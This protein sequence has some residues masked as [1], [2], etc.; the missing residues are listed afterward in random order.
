MKL[1]ANERIWLGMQLDFYR[2]D[3]WNRILD[4]G[5]APTGCDPNARVTGRVSS[6]GNLKDTVWVYVSGEGFYLIQMA[7]VKDSR[8][9]IVSEMFDWTGGV[10]PQLIKGERSGRYHISDLKYSNE[11]YSVYRHGRGGYFVVHNGTGLMLPHVGAYRPHN[12]SFDHTHY[13]KDAKAYADMVLDIDGMRTLDQPP[14]SA[15]KMLRDRL[16]QLRTAREEEAYR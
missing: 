1:T 2:D 13:L 10:T 15:V 11:Y 14:P 16:A 12:R 9:G 8:Y 7:R 6:L 4:S 5:Y 3:S